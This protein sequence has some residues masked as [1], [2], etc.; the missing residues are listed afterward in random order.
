VVVPPTAVVYPAP[1]TPSGGWPKGG[2]NRISHIRSTEAIQKRL[3]ELE[4]LPAG[5]A[6]GSYGPQ[7]STAV[8][9]LQQTRWLTPVDGVYG[10]G[11]DGMLFPPA[12]SIHGVDYSFAR[13]DIAMM[14]S[15]GVRLAG[16]YVWNPKYADGV[17]INKGIDRA[18]YDALKAAGIDPFF[19][20]ETYP[21]DFIT[22]FDTG[23]RHATDA[24][25]LI[26]KLGLPNLPIHFNVDR[27]ASASDIPG[28]LEGLRGAA[29]V[30]G[31]GRT[32]LYGQ[33]S[34]I[35]AAFDADLISH[36]CQTYAWSGDGR[37]STT[38]DPRAT[39][40][41]WQNT[42]WPTV[43]GDSNTAQIDYTRAVKRDFGQHPVAA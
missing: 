29:S 33:Y 31:K 12:G 30:I 21:E 16:R 34:V 38:W 22:G 23:V 7:T 1:V 35:K 18:E 40:Q 41:Q 14:K 19:F 39:T 8:A 15:R 4:F 6:D 27:Q 37:G 20:Y 28:I 9:K 11:S 5:S 3:I 17:R 32:A 42:Q 26:V 25:A 13:P 36:A 2:S 24:Q 10:D 43:P